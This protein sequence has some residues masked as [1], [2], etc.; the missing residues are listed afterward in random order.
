M[1]GTFGVREGGGT[2]MHCKNSD[3]PADACVCMPHLTCSC[4][5]RRYGWDDLN[6][7]KDFNWVSVEAPSDTP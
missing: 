5:G 4:G 2:P 7:A 1:T 3:T 6:V